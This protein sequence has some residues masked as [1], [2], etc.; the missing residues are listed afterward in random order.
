MRRKIILLLASGLGLGFIPI[1]PGTFGTLGGVALAFPFAR[2]APVDSLFFLIGFFLLA[3]YLA[4][5]ASKYL[6]SVDPAP[7]VI[8][9]VIGYLVAMFSVPATA[10]NLLIA[11][12]LFRIFDI[13]KPAPAKWFD[14]RHEWGGI[15]IVLDDIVAGLYANII[16]R[17][18]IF[19]IQ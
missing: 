15:A 18:I 12:I 2:L 17:I 11:F 10:T 8:D 13:L 6:G 9:E 16:V 1:V 4:D 19:F 3:I 14:S 5:E 7:V